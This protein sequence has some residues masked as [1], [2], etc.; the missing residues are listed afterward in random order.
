MPGGKGSEKIAVMACCREVTR[1]IASDEFRE[2]NWRQ[3]LAVR[4]HLLMCCHCQ[5]YAK[6][7]GEIG[8]AARTLWS[9]P[10][11]DRSTIERLE[12]QILESVPDERG[13]ETGD[14]RIEPQ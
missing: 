13:T 6:Q 10:S 5:R 12:R 7:L 1:K 3:R 9:S 14:A 8:S 11:Q 2:A 4:F